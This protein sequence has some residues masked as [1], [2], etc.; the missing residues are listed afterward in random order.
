MNQ[1]QPAPPAQ[2]PPTQAPPAQPAAAAASPSL[3]A[4]H[5]PPLAVPAPLAPPQPLLWVQ[6]V[7]TPS[8]T[9]MTP[10]QVQW[11]R[12]YTTKQYRRLKGNSTEKP[13]TWMSSSRA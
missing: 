5:P 2:A 4:P 8:L 6:D 7:P 1:G 13:T 10:T 12:S 3:P 9:L 11:Q